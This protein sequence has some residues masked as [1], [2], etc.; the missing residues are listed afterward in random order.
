VQGSI[1][2]TNHGVGVVAAVGLFETTQVIT[3][4]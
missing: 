1:P 2:S 4:T 3:G